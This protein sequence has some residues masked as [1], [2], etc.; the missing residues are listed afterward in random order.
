MSWKALARTQ[1]LLLAAALGGCAIAPF[2]GD[3]DARVDALMAEEQYGRAM[4]T[5]AYVPKDDPRHLH[6][7]RRLQD[8]RKLS[9][10]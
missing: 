7:A 6:Y 10:Q 1:L 3:V 2:Q 5:L 8:I 4:Q 9:E